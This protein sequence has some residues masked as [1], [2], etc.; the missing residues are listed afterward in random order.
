ME[1]LQWQVAAVNNACAGQLRGWIDEENRARR[2]R[3]VRRGEELA[4]CGRAL[5][6]VE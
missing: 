5:E 6:A 1:Y 2:R 4:E 3:T